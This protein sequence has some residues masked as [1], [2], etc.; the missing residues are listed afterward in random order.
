MML[1]VEVFYNL[2]NNPEYPFGF[3][4][5]VLEF[6]SCWKAPEEAMGNRGGSYLT[7]FSSDGLLVEIVNIVGNFK[8][9]SVTKHTGSH[10]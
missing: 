10:L 7:F 9:C 8:L 1:V 2:F 6:I 5:S 3:S 4:E